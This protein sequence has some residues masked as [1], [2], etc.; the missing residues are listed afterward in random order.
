M[1]HCGYVY[2][3]LEEE[4][5]F[6][7]SAA[8]PELNALK[9]RVEDGISH[10]FP[11]SFPLTFTFTCAGVLISFACIDMKGNLDFD[12]VEDPHLI[13]SLLKMYLRELPEPLM[14]FDL[15]T[16]FIDINS[17]LSFSHTH[18]LSLIL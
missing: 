17:T 9:Q 10:T 7:R 18:T 13:S 4:G 6:R 12:N 5:I 11:F 14:T 8:L 1:C 3:G 16:E 15:Y 2:V